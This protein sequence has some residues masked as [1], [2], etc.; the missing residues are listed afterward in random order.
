MNQLYF[1]DCLHILRD[2]AKEYPQGIANLIYLDPPFNSKR[3]YNMLFKTPKGHDSD[4]Q[5]TAFEDSWHWGAQAEH[6]YDELLRQPNTDVAGMMAALRSFLGENDMMAYLTMMANRLLVM[7]SVLKDTG[8]I[9]LHCDPTASHYLKI[10]LDG[11]FGK[12]QFRNE[13]IWPRTNAH[14]IASKHF[15]RIHETIF[16][17]SKTEEYTWNP[18]FVDFSQKQIE[19]YFL[20]EATGR[21]VTGQDLTMTGNPQRNF[22]WRGTRPPANRGWGLNIDD[23]EKLWEKGLI[24]TKNDGTPRLDGKKVFLDEKMGKPATDI[25][26]EIDRIGNTSRERLGY[27]TQKPIALLERI[28]QASSKTGDVVLDPFCGCGTAVHAAQKLGR[29]WIGV[30]VTHLAISLIKS[31]LI[32]AFPGMQFEVHGVPKDLDGAR[33]LASLDKYQFQWWACSLVGAQPYKGKKKG[34]DTGID[35]LI[36]FQDEKSQAKKIIVQ[37]KGGENVGIGDVK[38]LI[39][40]V[41]REKAQI[42]LFVTLAEPTKPMIREA[43]SAGFY[44]SP[45]SGKFP[46]I[47]ILTIDGI[48]SHRE[49]PQYVDFTSGM[50][51]KKA[52]SEGDGSVQGTFFE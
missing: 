10:L 5:I 1:G 26:M 42:G 34:S 29:G 6:E 4:A 33:E 17:Y 44:E 3:D 46:K 43:A 19:R 48:L 2:L 36:Y 13:L 32:D 14:N 47:Q 30:D 15:S 51:F 12:E 41:E 49:R 27:P 37:V 16:F 45:H 11:V 25:W 39:A 50:T 24:L 21:M 23:L 28:I 31:R 18:I 35:G 8:S 40:T 9:Y 52:L 38:N 7:H 20:D 22:E